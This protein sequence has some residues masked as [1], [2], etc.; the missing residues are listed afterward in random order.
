MK[1]T[2]FVMLVL[3]VLLAGATASFAQSLPAR[4]VVNENA[5]VFV[6]PDAS[7]QPLRVAK[8]GSALN[9]IASDVNSGWYRVEFQDPQFGRRVGYVEKRFVTAML[10]E[11]MD[12]TIPEVPQTSLAPRFEAQ[13]Q[14][15]RPSAGQALRI[16]SFETSAGW[17]IQRVG[18][19]TETLGWSLNLTKNVNQWFST[20]TEVSGQYGFESAD[21]YFGE[22]KADAQDH[23]FLAGPKFVGRLANGRVT[24]YGQFVGGL[25][26]ARAHV[27]VFDGYLDN[28]ETNLYPAIQPGGGIEVALTDRIGVRMAVDARIAFGEGGH[29]TA[30]R[31]TPGV[32][33]RTGRQ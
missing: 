4:V 15:Y 27:N 13:P 14:T 20:A 10:P 26:L 32:V 22:V 33:I 2:L 30:W 24:P 1:K 6:Q 25:L 23:A 3:L 11:S 16:P 8:A 21:T 31:F 18:G 12:L 29:V 5:P 17:A 7:V 19:E 28:S 9:V